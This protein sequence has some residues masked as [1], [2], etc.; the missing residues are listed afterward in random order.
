MIT[1]VQKFFIFICVPFPL[2]MIRSTVKEFTTLS[3]PWRENSISGRAPRTTYKHSF[4]GTSNIPRTNKQLGIAIM[5]SNMDHEHM[6]MSLNAHVRPHLISNQK[7]SPT[8]TQPASL[9]L[10]LPAELRNRIYHLVFI[11]QIVR[12]VPWQCQFKAISHS[13]HTYA[14]P[15]ALLLVCRQIHNEAY[16]LFLARSIFDITQ[17]DSRN[18]MLATLMPSR[19]SIIESIMLDQHVIGKMTWGE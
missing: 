17:I 1:E 14:S 3:A 13:P 6:Y 8:P 12:V 9:L 2:S 11:H 16:T 5:M 4:C 15:V 18:E 19:C 7:P 10:C